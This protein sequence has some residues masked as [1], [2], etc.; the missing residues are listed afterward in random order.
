MI[1]DKQRNLE[2]FPPGPARV[3]RLAP[4]HFRKNSKSTWRA[5][6][7]LIDAMSFKQPLA[8]AQIRR[9]LDKDWSHA[10]GIGDAENGRLR[11]SLLAWFYPTGFGL[12]RLIVIDRI[13]VLP[14]DRRLGVGRSLI[15]GL[16]EHVGRMPGGFHVMLTERDTLSQLFFRAVGFQLA[17]IDKGRGPGGQDVYRFTLPEPK[18]EST[19]RRPTTP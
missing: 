9:R 15:E 1:P 2:L 13:A 12:T 6:F 10:L 18:E 5:D 14:D 8:I 7:E 3:V 19:L 4:H 17:H 16:Q 11:G